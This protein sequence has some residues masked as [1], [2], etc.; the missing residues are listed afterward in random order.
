MISSVCGGGESWVKRSGIHISEA[1]VSQFL[2]W[3]SENSL[4]RW[5]LSKDLEDFGVGVGFWGTHGYIQR[6]VFQAEKTENAK[7]ETDICLLREAS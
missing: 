7:S 3:P 2:T 1:R 4:N 5:Y 6:K